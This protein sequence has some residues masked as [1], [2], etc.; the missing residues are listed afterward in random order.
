MGGKVEIA[1]S[2]PTVKVGA[3]VFVMGVGL[4][5]D[6]NASRPS[7]IGHQGAVGYA[8]ARARRTSSA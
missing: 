4:T 5:I 3:G 1:A 7:R 2:P 8:L 6:D